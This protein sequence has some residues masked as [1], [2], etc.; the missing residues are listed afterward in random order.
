MNLVPSTDALLFTA[1]EEL[2]T[3]DIQWFAE[4]FNEMRCVMLE[5]SGIGLAMPQV[6]IGKRAF[7]TGYEDFPVVINPEFIPMANCPYIS[8]LEGCLSKPGW[9]TYVRRPAEIHA[10]WT[11]AKG[12]RKGQQLWGIEARVF[13]HL[14]DILNGK[15]IFPREKSRPPV[16]A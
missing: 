10:K 3:E 13:M 4:T 6:G 15:P 1:A 12:H 14:C 9:H 5:H 16:P 7:V 11:D 8:R 2:T